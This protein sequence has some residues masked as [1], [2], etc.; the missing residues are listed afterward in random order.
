MPFFQLKPVLHDKL[1][2]RHCI[3]LVI[4]TALWPIHTT[5]LVHALHS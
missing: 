1:G 3:P 4:V 2:T 5:P